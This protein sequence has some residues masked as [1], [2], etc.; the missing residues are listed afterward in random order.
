MDTYYPGG[1]M[2]KREFGRGKPFIGGA[3][4][5]SNKKFG[6]GSKSDANKPLEDSPAPTKSKKNTGNVVAIK[7]ADAHQT[8]G[9]VG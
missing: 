2:R 4:D 1:K 6:T 3:F 9:K 5:K 7:N 8:K